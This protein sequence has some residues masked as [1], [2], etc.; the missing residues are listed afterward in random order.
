MFF[1][2]IAAVFLFIWFILYIWMEVG[3]AKFQAEYNREK[4]KRETLERLTTDVD[5]EMRLSEELEKDCLLWPD[6][7]G[8]F[9]GDS[10]EWRDYADFSSGKLKALIVRMLEYRKLPRIAT[11]PFG[12]YLTMYQK[13]PS[14][15]KGN[16]ISL[17]RGWEMNEEFL[18]TVEKR[19]R[20]AG[21][22]AVVMC[23]RVGTFEKEEPFVPLR[24]LIQKN[25]P[26]ASGN[27]A[28]FFFTSE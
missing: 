25:G 7:V 11:S 28:R 14:A 3:K 1:I 26:G 24:E 5:L 8:N 12:F 6:I 27:R 10:K 17:R 9:M 20:S 2:P 4:V 13:S 21:Y 19:L 16:G 18:L 22:H 23:K 15:I